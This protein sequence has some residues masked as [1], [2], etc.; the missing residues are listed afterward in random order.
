MRLKQNG[1]WGNSAVA[2]AYEGLPWFTG[3]AVMAAS[4]PQFRIIALA[5]L[6]SRRRARNHDAQRFQV[7]RRRPASGRSLTAGATWRPRRS[8][9]RLRGHGRAADHRQSVCSPR[10]GRPVYAAA[11]AAL[12]ARDNS[13]LMPSS[14]SPIRAEQG[15]RLQRDRNDALRARHAGE[16]LRP[17]IGR[18]GGLTCTAP[19]GW[20]EHRAARARADGARRDR[21]SDDVDDQP[22]DGGRA[23]RCRRW[24]RALLVGAHYGVQILR[25]AWGYGSDVGGRRTPWIVGGMAALALGAVGAALGTA[26][27]ATSSD[28]SASRLAAVVLPDHRRRRRARRALRFSR[29]WPT[30][31]A[32]LDAPLRRPPSG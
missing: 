20:I 21:R 13:P 1:W 28:R 11:V 5:L 9:A 32:P 22:G 8:A 30:G 15:R 27:A 29:C 31:V 14:W 4:F 19:L 17:A 18:N 12:A 24:F 3:A 7:D 16:R 25:P 26:L 23:C 6:Y 10:W 2:V